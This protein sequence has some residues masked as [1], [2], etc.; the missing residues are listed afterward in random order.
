MS[1]WQL[2]LPQKVKGGKRNGSSRLSC[3]VSSRS[4][5]AKNPLPRYLNTDSLQGLE[6]GLLVKSFPPLKVPL[7][8]QK[9]GI[10]RLPQLWSKG[11]GLHLQMAARCHTH[12]PGSGG[13]QEWEGLTLKFR[14]TTEARQ[15]GGGGRF[16]TRSSW[17]GRVCMKLWSR[18]LMVVNTNGGKYSGILEMPETWNIC[19]GKPKAL[20]GASLR[21]RPPTCV[22]GNRDEGRAAQAQWNPEDA[23]KNLKC[24]TWSF[25]VW[26]VPSEFGLVLAWSSL[27]NL[28]IFLFGIGILILHHCVLKVCILFFFL[29][30]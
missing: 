21:E 7:S 16:S 3:I 8:T 17:G 1:R 20:W 10:Q 25:R 22:T 27:A 26:C 23:T 19:Q 13:R 29:P 30:L 12:G 28:M 9:L 24:K 14:E 11:T 6:G 5:W 18:N 2:L 15:H 4:A